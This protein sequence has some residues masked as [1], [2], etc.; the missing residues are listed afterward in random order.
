M[1]EL[2]A[3]DSKRNAQVHFVMPQ[4]VVEGL[5]ERVVKIAAGKLTEH[6]LR[7][8]VA[9][10]SRGH[11]QDVVEQLAQT[12]HQELSKLLDR[13]SIT[14]DSS[15]QQALKSAIERQAKAAR[16]VDQ[17]EGRRLLEARSR[18][19]EGNLAELR[20]MSSGQLKMR[21]LSAEEYIGMLK[22]WKSDWKRANFPH[23]KEG[24]IRLWQFSGVAFAFEPNERF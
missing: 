1:V 3:S 11:R 23:C 24:D 17:G 8:L 12:A 13:S 7:V 15:S 18:S 2:S 14:A 6:N 5:A 19:M 16:M 10:E 22:S 20:R 21:D 4:A 9:G